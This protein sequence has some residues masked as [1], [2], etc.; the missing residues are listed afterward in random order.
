MSAKNKQWRRYCVFYRLCGNTGFHQPENK[1]ET[2]LTP[3]TEDASKD[4]NTQGKNTDIK[5]KRMVS[6]MM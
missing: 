3:P 2:G 4:G 1:L 5:F 6:T